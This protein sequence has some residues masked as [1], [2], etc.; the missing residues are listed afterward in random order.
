M[1]PPPPT[2]AREHPSTL[3]NRGEPSVPNLS[4]LHTIERMLESL[5]RSHAHT[6]PLP[7][8]RGYGPFPPPPHS[9]GVLPQSKRVTPTQREQH[10][11]LESEGGWMYPEAS[12]EMRQQPDMYRPSTRQF[13]SNRPY[14]MMMQSGGSGRPNANNWAVEM[15]RRRVMELQQMQMKER[16]E[17]ER[18]QH[19]LAP[20]T[21]P[22]VRLYYSFL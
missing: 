1:L 16:M 2:A 21:Q 22:K 19:N 20:S 18:M 7:P 5:D 11:P 3:I 17:R 13:V 6:G 14:Q 12:P 15:E 4:R 9:M 8:S 10:P